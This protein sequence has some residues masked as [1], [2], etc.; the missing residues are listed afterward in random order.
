MFSDRLLV[1]MLNGGGQSLEDLREVRRDTALL[2]LL[3]WDE[4]WAVWSGP[5]EPGTATPEV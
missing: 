2:D 4:R 5:C 3:G 1:L